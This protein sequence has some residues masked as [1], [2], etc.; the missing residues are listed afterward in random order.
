MLEPL[1]IRR[2]LDAELD[3]G[4]LEVFGTSKPDDIELL[5]RNDEVRVFINGEQEGK[6]DVSRVDRIVVRAGG[7]NDRV[8]INPEVQGASVSG[9]GGSDTLIG[10]GGNDTLSGDDG[11]DHL[12]GKGGADRIEGGEGFDSADYRFRTEDLTLSI[13]GDANDGANGG[14]EGDNIALDV[15]RIV[16]GSGNDRIS[17]S[18]AD[19]SITAQGGDDTVNGGGGNDSIDGDGGS[20]SIMG[21]GGNDR[22]TGGADRDTLEGGDGDDVFLAQDSTV[23][24]LIGGA[25]DEDSLS[26]FDEKDSF[27]GIELNV[28]KPREPEVVVRL[29]PR[30]ISVGESGIDF[31][32]VVE[33]EAG[34][35][36]TFT[37]RNDGNG[38]LRLSDLTVPGGFVVTEGLDETIAP[39]G[40]DTFTVRMQSANV[41]TKSG[42]ITFTTND[43]D[44]P[45]YSFTVGGA[46]TPPPQPEIAVARGGNNLADGGSVDFGA[47]VQGATAPT[48][49]FVVRNTGE[50]VLRLGTVVVPAGFDVVDG[51]DATIAPG[52][53][54]T[55][56]IRMLTGAVGTSSGN[57]SINTN[58]ADEDPFTFSVSGRVNEPPPAEIVV[59]RGGNNVVDG[60]GDFSF[61]TVVQGDEPPTMTFVVRNAGDQ[62]LR[63]GEL[64]VPAG[65]GIV[66]QLDRVIS[67][68][69][70]DGFTI[71][72][73]S[74]AVGT[75]G[76]TVSFTTNDPDEDP[77]DFT[78]GGVV[79]TPPRPEI[80]VTQGDANL[81]DDTGVVAFGGATQGTTGPT[82]VFT[83]RNAGDAVL[84]TSDLSIPAGYAVVEGLDATIAPGASDAFSLRMRTDAVGAQNGVVS[85]TTNDADEDPY[86]FRVTGSVAPPRRPDVAVA[87]GNRK[88]VDGAAGAVNFG[89]LV[90]GSGKSR[91]LTFTVS[92]TGNA[93][94][95]AGKITLPRGFTL[96]DG[97]N[98]TL[99]PKESDTIAV[100]FDGGKA[101]RYAGAMRI[102][103]NDPD[104]DPF[105]VPLTGTVIAADIGVRFGK[106]AIVDGSKKAV[107]FG[108]AEAGRTAPARTF[109]VVN[110]GTAALRIDDVSLPDGYSMAKAPPRVINPGKSAAFTVRLDSGAAGRAAGRIVITSSDPDAEKTYDFAVTGTV[111]G[112]GA[113]Q[114]GGTL[115][116]T[117][118]GADDD[119][120]LSGEGGSVTVSANGSTVGSFGGVSVV[121]VEGAGGNDRLAAT[122]LSIPVRLSGGAGDDTLLGGRGADRLFGGEGNDSLSGGLGS[123][124]MHGEGGADVVNGAD[125]TSDAMVDG[126]AGNDRVRAD[127]TDSKSGT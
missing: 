70:N 44:E 110:A 43:G 30:D 60:K 122:G 81:P 36:R 87:L 57:V 75:P 4:V 10:G 2:L 39:G 17:G 32:T 45:A 126:G 107:N 55:F 34:P 79:R 25:G 58:D 106:T 73:N 9:G 13:D 19:N 41:G 120:V 127:P 92:N 85:F 123:D 76:G 89:K 93:P 22:L 1:E 118:T 62:P 102:A 71:R 3:D 94:M 7:G 88:F 28:P 101:G 96:V 66:E 35:T 59:T 68:G 80:V 124:E 23:D 21:D 69:G 31:G 15:E 33:G 64:N 20:D 77:F 53:N 61:G 114:S 125:G 111:R 24:V 16:A 65:F 90:Q 113:S 98:K 72:M 67:P 54:D 105:D 86:N 109:T 12:D 63:L 37:V 56:S 46:V 18:A 112:V 104:E 108:I 14:A 100:R 29:G 116:V 26:D 119:I 95:T 40:G 11:A 6:F 82:R 115:T 121:N 50:G 99:Q 84:R 48:I 97:L 78:V 117:G 27:T 8:L 52:G 83:V 51:L 103:S 49:A 42:A 91:T 5:V 47:V 38:T 74:G